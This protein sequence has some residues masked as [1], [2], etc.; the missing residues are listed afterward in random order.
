MLREFT[1]DGRGNF[2]LT[3]TSGETI[4]GGNGSGLMS[5]AGQ[6]ATRVLQETCALGELCDGKV[7]G[8]RNSAV[9]MTAECFNNVCPSLTKPQT[10]SEDSV[11]ISA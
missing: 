8:V 1:R 5:A 9:Y 6:R 4:H 7:I 3:L 2:S 10:T 11:V